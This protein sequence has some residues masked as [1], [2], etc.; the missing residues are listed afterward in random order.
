MLSASYFWVDSEAPIQ[1]TSPTYHYKYNE[2][3]AINDRIKTVVDWLKLPTEK[4]PHIITFYMPEVVSARPSASFFNGMLILSLLFKSNQ[5]DQ[6]RN[7][8]QTSGALARVGFI[9]R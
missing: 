6:S 8:V 7:N 5:Y 9:S 2:T 4:R 3:T 1:N